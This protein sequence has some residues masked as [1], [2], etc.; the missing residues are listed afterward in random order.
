MDRVVSHSLCVHV[1]RSDLACSLSL[2][3]VL[4]TM[5]IEAGEV[6]RF[7]TAEEWYQQL[8]T[9]DEHTRRSR[10]WLADVI[11]C[12]L[13]N[14]FESLHDLR[15]AS[16]DTL[17]ES[18]PV[19]A[20]LAF[21]RRALEA[22]NPPLPDAN[23]LV[24]ARVLAEQGADKTARRPAV[25]VDIP[26]ALARAS[27]KDL[28]AFTWPCVDLVEGLS[29]DL[30]KLRSKGVERPFVYIDLKKCVPNWALDFAPCDGG[31]D[32]TG[33]VS[34]VRAIA[35]AI[36]AGPSTKKEGKHL[37]HGCW[38]AA[39]HRLAFASE[40][41]GMWTFASAMAHLDMCLRVGEEARMRGLP[42][43]ISV[44]YDEVCRKRWAELAR[45]RVSGFSVDC[46]CASIC[47]DSLS[48]AEA[49]LAAARPSK[50]QPFGDRLADGRREPPPPP[51][52]HVDMSHV[53]KRRRYS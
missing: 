31:S 47:K 1:Q 39:F 33:E 4:D 17:T 49:L 3:F 35:D 52:A 45:A 44:T 8:K 34:A 25:A 15:G 41:A 29:A 38:I 11:A 20:K 53:H 7:G 24:A 30:N 21:L 16:S 9:I 46:E 51:L 12:L 40:I 36:M 22:A 5:A 18:K 19:G 43:Y 42:H 6:P 2:P 32:G 28:P 26:G 10:E 48:R 13:A 14:G 23:A 27:L 37:S 50:P